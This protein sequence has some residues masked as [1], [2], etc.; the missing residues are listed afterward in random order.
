MLEKTNLPIPL[1]RQRSIQIQRVDEVVR[2]VLRGSVTDSP[3][4]IRRE[5]NHRFDAID[6]EQW[7]T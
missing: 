2:V 5:V 7:S 4:A 6:D 1:R 3:V